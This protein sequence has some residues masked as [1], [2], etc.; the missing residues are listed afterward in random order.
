M[1]ILYLL[2]F[3][4]LTICFIIKVPIGLSMISAG[5]I[6]F[7]VMGKDVGLAADIAMS[8]LYSSTVLIAIPLFIF[9]AN[10]MNSGKVT[11][12]M[13][14]FAKALV[15]RKRG[16][17]AYINIIV[18]LIF[19]GMS[20]SAL[21][22]AAGIGTMEITEMKKDGYDTAF[23]CAIT[24]STA[25][26]G[27]IFPP[28]IPL[29]IY[30]L[31]AETSVGSLFLGGMI[32][33]ILICGALGVYVW[34]ISKKRQYPYGVK[35]SFNEFLK[36]TLKALPA[37]ITPLILLGGIYTGIVTA[38]EAGALAALYAIII[39]T[40]AYRV[41]KVK[42]FLNAVKNTVKQTALVMTI[43][44]GAFIISHIVS[45]FGIS[46][47]IT[48]WF[49]CI[50]ES[51]YVFLLIVNVVFL[52]LG[53]FLDVGVIQFI[54]LPLVIPAAVALGVNLIHFGVIVT[55]NMMIGLS[56]PPFGMLAFISSG[57]G[58]AELKNVFKELIPMC[59]VMIGIL[60]LITFIPE[61]VTFIPSLA[62]S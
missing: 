37:L 59:C 7:M 41:L 26:V 53:M 47:K 38:T 12:H 20:G 46:D 36:Y 10:I 56:T 35:F 54:F 22:D 28:S 49:L 17:L 55:L 50:S 3:I 30:G 25:T 45:S 44:I 15:G 23:S 21:A 5:I 2:P 61:L 43:A 32:P 58:K 11:E 29:V 9:T 6:F 60:L 57:V 14:T 52:F 42:D 31:L 8:S 51:K 40:L 24:A 16:A 13:F 48:D 1:N 34:Y 27:P 4:I 19:S 33:A 18:S 39:S 62:M